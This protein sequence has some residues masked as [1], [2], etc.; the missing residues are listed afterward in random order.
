LVGGDGW[1]ATWGA[2]VSMVR[3]MGVVSGLGGGLAF[4]AESF[5]VSKA[6]SQSAHRI[7]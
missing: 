3:A 4:T 5:D 1:F 7:F 2:E 6:S